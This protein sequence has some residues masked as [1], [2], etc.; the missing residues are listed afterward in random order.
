MDLRQLEAFAAVMSSGSITGAA[1]L[2]GRSQPALTRLIQDLEAS[3]GFSLLH[4]SGP[5][6]T[7]TE[8]GLRFYR[9]VEPVLAWLRQLRERADA[10]AADRPRSLSIASIASF[11]V[12][13][14][15]AALRRLGLQDLPDQIHIR[16][17]IAEQV[18]QDIAT[19]VSEIGVT[20]LPVDHPALEIHWIGE[21]P[22]VAAIAADDPLVELER[23]PLLAL[24][25]RRLI[26][27][28]N[29]FRWRRRVDLALE[30]N[31]VTPAAVL[32]T[33]TSNAAIMSAR[34]GLG[35]ALIEPIIA[36][37]MPV[38]GVVIRP[39]D[40]HIA[41]YWAIITP[42][43]RPLAAQ[44]SGLIEKFEEIARETIPGF[45]KHPADARQQLVADLARPAFPADQ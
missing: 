30:A 41:F 15:P 45:V 22:C 24:G 40:V 23:I 9:E 10:I 34:A 14:L 27:L 37:G 19:Q 31:G 33:N 25:G 38:E 43:G 42:Y 26:T 17:A 36:Y 21:A 44:V 18:V 39:I 6:V 7:T 3:L 11:S 16:T 5:R 1:R 28:A 2:L 32:D 13:M 29:P 20:S 4:R 12:G 35:V 8:Q